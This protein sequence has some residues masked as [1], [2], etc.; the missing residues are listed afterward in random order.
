[1]ECTD[2]PAKKQ[3]SEIAK[4]LYEGQVNRKLGVKDV[5]KCPHTCAQH[6][7]Q[8]SVRAARL[9]RQSTGKIN[10]RHYRISNGDVS[11]H[12]CR[13]VVSTMSF[14]G[15]REEQLQVEETLFRQQCCLAVDIGLASPAT[16]DTDIDQRHIVTIPV[17]PD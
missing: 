16:V 3:P 8:R 15:I 9:I 6:D 12:Q 1:M 2:T 5:A 17:P 10:V 13:N 14:P 7:F 11:G 4:L